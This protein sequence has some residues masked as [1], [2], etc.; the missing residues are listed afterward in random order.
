ME[1]AILILVSIFTV[2]MVIL[3]PKYAK[4]IHNQPKI[5]NEKMRQEE[6]EKTGAKNGNNQKQDGQPN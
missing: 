1:T 2:V 5:Q 3:L 4:F 6:D